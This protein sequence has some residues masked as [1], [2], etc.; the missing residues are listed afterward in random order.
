MRRAEAGWFDVNPIPINLD[1]EYRQGA[2]Q[3]VPGRGIS[4][5][6]RV[7]M[8]RCIQ[9]RSAHKGKAND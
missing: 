1:R 8:L 6:R 5:G 7:M 4:G 9:T 2:Q 3:R